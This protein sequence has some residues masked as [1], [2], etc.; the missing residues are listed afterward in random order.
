MV[1]TPTTMKLGWIQKR[2]YHNHHNQ[3]PHSTTHLKDNSK[4]NIK[5]NF[6]DIFKDIFMNIFN[7]ILKNNLKDNFKDNFESNFN[8]NSNC[9]GRGRVRRVEE[10][11]NVR[12][13][14]IAVNVQLYLLQ[15][16]W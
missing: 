1:T 10:K 14:L 5:D 12:L 11:N 3:P 15:N 16:L 4:S 2:L 8:D 7:D 9:S 6:K 13:Q